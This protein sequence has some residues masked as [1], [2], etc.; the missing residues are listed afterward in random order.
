VVTDRDRAAVSR[1]TALQAAIT[2]VTAGAAGRAFGQQTSPPATKVS[3]KVAQYQETPKNGQSCSI[4]VNFEPPHA[5]KLVEG[6]I[7]P[8]GWCLLFAPKPK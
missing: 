4:C 7:V 5:C 8:N 3:Q 6:N 2:L 1:R